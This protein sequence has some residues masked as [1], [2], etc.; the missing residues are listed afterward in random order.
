MTPSD[1]SGKTWQALTV[2]PVRMRNLSGSSSVSTASGRSVK[3][4]QLNKS[5]DFKCIIIT[6]LILKLLLNHQ[7]QSLFNKDLAMHLFAEA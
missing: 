7:R 4:I 3:G 5:K 6:F 1:L 2:Q